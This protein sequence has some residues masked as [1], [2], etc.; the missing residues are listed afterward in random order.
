M[1]RYIIREIRAEGT[2]NRPEFASGISAACVRFLENCGGEANAPGS[3]Q[4]A[5]DILKSRGRIVCDIFDL[6]A[7]IIVEPLR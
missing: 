7:T 4:E 5:E 2:E 6:G 1:I 3:L